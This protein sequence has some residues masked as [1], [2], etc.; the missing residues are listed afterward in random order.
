MTLPVVVRPEAAVDV[1]DARDDYGRQ[2]ATLGDQFATA[3]DEA[4]SQ[5]AVTP[6]LF[7]VVLRN[8]RRT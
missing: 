4:I 2:R 3:L 1:L 6:E 5:I 8:V 7:A